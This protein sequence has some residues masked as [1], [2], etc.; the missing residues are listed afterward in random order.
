[1]L[2]TGASDELLLELLEDTRVLLTA[3]QAGSQ[4]RIGQELSKR[5]ECIDKI[6]AAGGV[7][8]PRSQSRK[9]LINDILTLDAKACRTIRKLAQKSGSAVLN[10]QKKTAGVLKYSYNQYDLSSGHL[11]DKRD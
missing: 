6:I 10:Q 2:N 1:M 8:G 9:A 5:Q 11:I 4:K 3:A 7:V